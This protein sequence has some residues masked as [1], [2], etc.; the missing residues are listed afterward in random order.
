MCGSCFGMIFI[1]YTDKIPDIKDRIG[2]AV[3]PGLCGRCS[4]MVFV[5]HTDKN[6]DI[7]G[8]IDIVVFLGLQGSLHNHKIGGLDTHLLEV[9]SHAFTEYS[10]PVVP[11]ANI[12]AD[13]LTKLG[14]IAATNGTDNHLVLWDLHLHDHIGSKI[15]TVCEM[16]SNS[17]SHNEV[18]GDASALSIGDVLVIV[19]SM[20]TTSCTIDD[21]KKF[22]H[23]L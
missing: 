10:K 1:E 19:P 9:K 5:K 22:C 23:L 3:F 18:H 21:F 8:R 20:T 4:G 11:H 16:V 13:S 17:L 12:L 7:K 2:I 6:P 15:D 14:H